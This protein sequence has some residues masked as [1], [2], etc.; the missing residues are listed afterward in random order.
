[1][2]RSIF[3]PDGG[4][5]EHS[6]STFTGPDGQSASHLP[7]EVVDGRADAAANAAADS[8]FGVDPEEVPSP[9][10]ADADEAARRLA[11][12]TEEAPPA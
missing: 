11:E 7:P 3:D 10:A 2:T 8:P 12:M 6:G 4:E 1:M 5:T 9:M